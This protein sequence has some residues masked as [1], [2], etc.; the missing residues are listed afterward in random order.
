MEREMKS[1]AEAA[2]V[3]TYRKLANGIQLCLTSS[4][5]PL[6]SSKYTVIAQQKTYEEAYLTNS[7]HFSK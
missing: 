1:A 3:G 4:H 6:D 2:E 5:K 7:N